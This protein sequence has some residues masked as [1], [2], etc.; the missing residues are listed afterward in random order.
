MTAQ[1]KVLASSTSGDLITAS[2][3]AQERSASVATSPSNDVLSSATWQQ[4]QQQ[5]QQ[6][7]PT[8]PS[9]SSTS[10]LAPTPI[11]P[12]SRGRTYRIPNTSDN[13]TL[14]IPSSNNT[15]VTQSAGNSNNANNNKYATT[16]NSNNN[17]P[18]ALWA[19]R[20]IAA[21]DFLMNVPLRAEREI[22]RAGLSGE[23]WHIH[24]HGH[25][26]NQQEQSYGSG[27]TRLLSKSSA[28][29]A[30]SSVF[31]AVF[32]SA[33]NGDDDVKQQ[34]RLSH[35]R[36]SS[37]LGRSSNIIDEEDG[38]MSTS[39]TTSTM[40]S[41]LSNNDSK[42]NYN[43]GA[44]GLRWWEKLIQKDKRFF[45][46]AN[47]QVQRRERM[48]MEERELERPDS[49]S[50]EMVGGGAA[51]PRVVLGELAGIQYGRMN[52]AG[53]YIKGVIPITPTG[54][55]MGV[56][57]ANTTGAGGVPG[58]RLDGRDAI[59]VE[60]PEEF[61]CRPPRTAARQAAV[62]EW[63]IKVAWHGIENS[64]GGA[65]QENKHRHH[66][67]HHHHEQ[68]HH[69]NLKT[70]K[71]LLDGRVFFSA[72]KS[73]PVMVF[74]TIKYEPQKEEAARRRK[75][76]EELG[77][78][79]TQFVLPERDWRGISYRALLPQADNHNKAFNRLLTSNRNTPKK[80]KKKNAKVSP[81][82][83]PSSGDDSL[84]G[85][86]HDEDDIDTSSTSS[87]DSNTYLPG[88]LDDPQMVQGRHRHVMIGDKVTGPIVSS[89]IQFV[90]PSVLKA[91]LN[92]QFRERFDKWEPP[93]S[94]RKFIGA[95]V[96]D[97]IYTLID[98]TETVLDDVDDDGG[99][100]RRQRS[101]SITAEREIIRMP[102]SLTLSKIRS[103]KQ[104]ALVACIRSKIEISTLA[105][106]CVYFERL[107]LDC[108]VDK[109]NRR[110][111]FAACLLL[112]AKVNESNSMIVYDQAIEAET[113]PNVLDSW[114][115]PN[116]KSGKIFESLIVFFTHDWALSMKQ[117]YAAE[118]IV[119]TALGFSLTATP[120]QVSFHFKR[121]LKVLEWDARSYLGSEMYQQW[122]DVLKE[123]SLRKERRKARKERRIKQNERKLMKKLQQTEDVKKRRSS[124]SDESHVRRSL[125]PLFTNEEFKTSHQRIFD[126]A[127]SASQHG[128]IN[129]ADVTPAI[130][131]LLSR[132]ARTNKQASVE[133]GIDKINP[134]LK[135]SI[136]VPNIAASSK[137]ANVDG[138]FLNADNGEETELREAGLF[139]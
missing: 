39:G 29:P 139:I 47:Q 28:V 19:T 96:I 81:R 10:G 27:D 132:L 50:L 64:D 61:R 69:P 75:K 88:F 14:G 86:G 21:L 73:Y 57:A 22:V 131:G 46:A 23:R 135:Y 16:N 30:G 54:N 137:T 130:R 9:F 85:D 107:C 53:D 110:L 129:K 106:A 101:G 15:L 118:W 31:G 43:S 38:R 114:V 7:I 8:G 128:S 84:S 1:H 104:Q 40:H 105:L 66:H 113:K 3:K 123:D 59:D 90:K 56:A 79:G 134:P 5:L 25:V 17:A 94:Q 11:K 51:G 115:K 100:M 12:T 97:G 36:Q 60:I 117:L 111:S 24:Y 49:A 42:A 37:G 83:G 102:P 127:P 65:H 125:S 26:Y 2:R 80:K 116:K 121:L 77:G 122:Q 91:D 33:G 76:L 4:H 112:A 92:K 98:P 119:F 6:P 32:G 41:L 67:R 44:G 120:L 136:S 99:D 95:K 87:S 20:E 68:P 93:K 82:D 124:A 89:T 63:E 18:E 133:K 13:S 45:S 52:A 109:S 55:T 70:R 58:R 62:R 103:L 35:E 74:S 78:G 108:R 48:E 34:Q 126:V 71:A 138:L 72:K